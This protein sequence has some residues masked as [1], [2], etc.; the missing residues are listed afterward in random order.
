MTAKAADFGRILSRGPQ[1]KTVGL[2][3]AGLGVPLLLVLLWRVLP[4][5][6]YARS[7][8]D[9]VGSTGWV[10]VVSFF[11]IY[12]VVTV[13]GMPRTPLHVG[14]GMI[15]SFPVALVLVLAGAT[16][17]FATT[18]TIAR[19]VARDWVC[20]RIA[21]SPKVQRLLDLVDEEGFKLV[22]LIRMNM[23]VPGV[24]KGYGFGTTNVPMRTYLPAS[25]LGFL[26]IAI[27]HVYLGWAGGRAILHDNGGPSEMEKWLMI[28]GVAVSLALVAGVYFFGKHALE[29]RYRD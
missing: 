3:A 1:W 27:A 7:C 12:L 21:Q 25:V 9:W 17:A 22:L 14:A 6:E 15:F 23:L 28:A 24:L 16:A 19:T 2:W 4:L 5:D 20:R 13:L 18:F 10:G 11:F 8:L 26:P 29:K